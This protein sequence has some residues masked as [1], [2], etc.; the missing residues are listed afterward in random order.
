MISRKYVNVR[1]LKSGMQIDQSII[2]GTGRLLV[3]RKAI[4]DDQM[5]QSLINMNIAGVYIREG[6]EETSFGSHNVSPQALEKIE[7]LIQEDRAKVVLSDTVKK[8]VNDG[9]TFLFNNPYSENLVNAVNS[10][11]DELMKAITE[12]DALAVDINI[13]KTSNEYTFKHSVDVASIAMIIAKQNKMSRLDIQRIG[14]S[15]LL[16]DL[17]KAVID[18]KILNKPDRLTDDE[19]TI[20]KKHPVYG[21]D[22]IKDREGI[23]VEVLRGVLQHH[24]K[25]NGVG[26]PL[27]LT[28]SQISPYAK[29]LAVADIYDALVTER[30]YKKG[31]SPRDAVEMLMS[32]TRELDLSVIRKLMNSVILYPVGDEV[33][34]SNGEMARVVENFPDCPTRP[35]VVGLS[36]GR[37]YNLAE[38]INCTSI[39]VE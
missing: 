24:E 26:Y 22:M 29:I 27:G 34:L 39:I 1:Q 18:N 23:S 35:K 11:S 5:I 36:T 30:P 8:R 19:F 14:T 28:V 13:L 15:G 31:F 37:V 38:D 21:Y 12:N 2:D 25:S 33:Q 4:L 7:K 17:G 3:V 32:M 6:E 10:I 20:I 9:V 16:H